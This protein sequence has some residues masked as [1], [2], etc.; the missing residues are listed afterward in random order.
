[1][2]C[3]VC[4]LKAATNFI[5]MRGIK[6]VCNSCIVNGRILHKGIAIGDLNVEDSCMIDTGE[7]K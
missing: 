2:K 5:T 6:P 7:K 1:M 4:G 3:I